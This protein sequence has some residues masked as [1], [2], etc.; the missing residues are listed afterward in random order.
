MVLVEWPGVG[1][2]LSSMLLIAFADL[3]SLLSIFFLFPLGDS[4]PFC[5]VRKIGSIGHT[6]V[7]IPSVHNQVLESSVLQ[8]WSPSCLRLLVH[9]RGSASGEVVSRFGPALK[10][11]HST[12]STP[13]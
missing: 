5:T 9:P 1:I 7:V 6:L 4:S 2:I 12:H 8:Q 3:R 10:S 11:L 13:H